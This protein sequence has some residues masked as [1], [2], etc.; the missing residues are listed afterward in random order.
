MIT[1]TVKELM[2]WLSE[3]PSDTKLH[4]ERTDV[5]E[6]E[7]MANIFIYDPAESDDWYES[8]DYS[9]L[10]YTEKTI[11]DFV[12]EHIEH[13][14]AAEIERQNIERS[15]AQTQSDMESKLKREHDY[16]VDH[17]WK[18]LMSAAA[19]GDYELLSATAPQLR[20]LGATKGLE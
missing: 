1:F 20:E 19:T 5:Y 11:E 18:Q 12:S 4:L 10:P 3:L 13:D 16:L 6:C 17:L 8:S 15:L 14:Y 7:G 2:D 9:S